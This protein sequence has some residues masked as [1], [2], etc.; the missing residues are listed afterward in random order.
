VAQGARASRSNLAA[1]DSDDLTGEEVH[2][3]GGQKHDGLS[4]LFRL[5][6]AFGG[7]AGDQAGFAVGIAG[8]AIPLLD[9]VTLTYMLSPESV[10]GD[11]RFDVFL[12][13]VCFALQTRHFATASGF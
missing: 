10:P 8:E 5:S 4:D 9:S 1:I 11:S 7:H 2:L 13:M 6:S 3:I 12:A